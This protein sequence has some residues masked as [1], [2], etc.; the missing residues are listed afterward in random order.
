MRADRPATPETSIIIRTF[1]EEKHL[2]RLFD[3]LD[4]QNNRNYEVIVVDSGS[5][6]R[7]R[8]IAG[9]RADKLI[10]ITSHDFT[11]GYSLNAGIKQ[12]RGRFIAIASAHTI[13]CH[14]DWL[15]DLIAPLREE[16]VAMT[17]GRQI[18][19]P[20]SR[21]GE[22]EDYDRLYGPHPREDTLTLL[23]ANN[24]NSAIRRDLW[25]QQPFDETL[26]GLEDIAWAK[27]WLQQ[28]YRVVYV[29]DA[30][31]HHL[32]EESW[33]QIRRRYYREAV[34]ARRI[35]IKSKR[36]VHSEI[37]TEVKA[38]LSDYARALKRTD[39]PVC[40]RL[41]Y[42][43]RLR[44]ILYFRT[45]KT[46]GTL[47]GLLKAHPMETQQEREDILFDRTSGG[48]LIHEPGK[49]SYEPMHVPE[50]KPG[51]V[52]IRVAHVAVCATDLEIFNGTLGYYKN[53]MAEYPIVPGHEFSG[54]IA[55]LGHNVQG[56]SEEDP[57]VVEC[58]QSCG[59][60]K[61]CRA[62]NFIG[63]DDRT[64][65]GVFRRNG[66]Y[67]DYVAVPSR[68]VHKLPPGDD[69]RRAA[70]CEPL[71]VVLKGMR[72]LPP[73]IN[74]GRQ[75]CA[76]LGAGPLGHLCA[77]T[78]AHFGHE[79]TAFD[80]IPER[81]A[82]L[83]ASGIATSGNLDEVAKFNIIVEV[84]GDPEVLHQA[85]HLSP[86]NTLILLLGLPY[87]SRPFSFETVAAY[88]KT[89]IGSVGSTAEDFREAIRLLPKLDL[90][91]YFQCMMPLKD[92][93]HGWEKSKAGNV[94]KVIL[95]PS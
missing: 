45:H 48:V 85:L 91:P 39:N 65:L 49:A 27:H 76:V 81:L 30:A 95:Y 54:R 86:A 74:G 92:F 67:A 56:L 63:C 22:A 6:D 25:D 33:Q 17:Y 40:Q 15:D 87:G 37:W 5:F 53:G 55:S 79:V 80:R 64:E 78:L 50:L 93:E 41:T 35:G 16:K 72:R 34:A 61:H 60:C 2:P 43:Q 4:R 36:T 77:L 57:V 46:Y 90:T 94:L 75:R 44:E 88:D 8:D 32:H 31:L 71:A 11:F 84:T 1:N 68:F 28:D 21:F 51:D 52:L 47:L 14:Q 12:A 7:S 10:R 9:E 23:R 38:I 42:S 20:C 62:G 82:L 73:S 83:S 70:L 89:V 3:A 19:A 69:L 13:P 58:I 18:G 29:P 59:V 26:T 66:A 24:A